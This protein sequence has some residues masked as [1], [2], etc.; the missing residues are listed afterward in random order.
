M[1]AE[2]AE[3]HDYR[4]VGADWPSFPVLKHLDNFSLL[5]L[6]VIGRTPMLWMGEDNH[7]AAHPD[8]ITCLHELISITG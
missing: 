5:A 6:Q 1:G 4:Q 3:G 7:I 2:A 8:L